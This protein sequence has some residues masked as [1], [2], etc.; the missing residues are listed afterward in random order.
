MI[1]HLSLIPIAAT[2][3]SPHAGKHCVTIRRKEFV[4]TICTEFQE[5]ILARDVLTEPMENLISRHGAAGDGGRGTVARVDIPGIGWVFVRDY[6]HGGLTRAVFGRRFFIPGRETREIHVLGA[7]RSRN[8]PVPVPVASAR[9]HCGFGRGYHARIITAEIP[10]T[11]SL[12]TTLWENTGQ[13]RDTAPLLFSTGKAIRSMHDAGIY[14][15]DLNM[16]NIL[17]N[18]SETV[19]IID[20]DRARIRR[21]LGMRE[22]IANLRRL[23]RSGRKLTRLHH[24]APSGWFSDDRFGELLRGYSGGNEDLYGRLVSQTIDFRPLKARSCIGW[25]LDDLL[26]RNK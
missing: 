5:E 19:F 18:E 17:V 6:R 10:R 8:L 20:F 12:V 23:L 4:F 7:A 26:Y 3:M 14:H 25:A 15:H 11:S 24:D 1:S 22:R 2:S 13:G 16:H 21:T 9:K